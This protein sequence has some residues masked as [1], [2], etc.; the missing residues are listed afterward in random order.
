MVLSA[1][2]GNGG[3]RL[4]SPPPG[5]IRIA[6]TQ[7]APEALD[8][9]HRPI[10][11]QLDSINTVNLLPDSRFAVPIQQ[12]T[13]KIIERKTF[14]PDAGWRSLRDSASSRCLVVVAN[15]R[16]VVVVTRFLSQPLR[17]WLGRYGGRGTTAADQW[18]PDPSQPGIAPGP[19]GA[20][21]RS[22]CSSSLWQPGCG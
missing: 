9:R 1:S 8:T 4:S 21:L 3:G 6:P 12:T 17:V 19:A 16:L 13:G 2:V 14:P 10:P 18:S 7:R 15:R 20:S 22:N 5:S 11:G